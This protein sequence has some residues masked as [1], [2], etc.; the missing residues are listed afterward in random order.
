MARRTINPLFWTLAQVGSR[1]RSGAPSAVEDPPLDLPRPQTTSIPTRH[2]D[3][4]ALVQRPRKTVDPAEPGPV[5]VHLHGGGFVN[6]NPAQDLHIARHL[7]AHLGVVVVLPD[8]DTAPKVRY[9]AA[10]EETVDIV[11][12]V[13][14]S[15]AAG[16]W[17]GN[18]LALSGVSAGAKLAIAACQQLHASAEPQP[19]AVALVV[20]VTD[21]VRIDRSSAIRRP[22]ISPWVQR[23]VAWAY[24]PDAARRGEALAS[25][26]LDRALSRALPPTLVL[27][28][29][30]DTLAP[31]GAELAQV[32]RAGGV[33]VE[34]HQYSGADHGFIAAKPT[35]TIR[36]ALRRM[37][38]FLRP[39]LTTVK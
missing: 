7:A 3:V 16:G 29:E 23:F 30:H 27:T 31:E 1:I 26:R 24:Y 36:D 19:R 35:E 4:R 38:V 34:H 10:E 8:Y 6:R 20:P 22:A 15:G 33:E 13:T 39:H 12:W 5:V 18:R 9:P 14:R 25:P 37:E 17:D 32:L 2:G 28:A 21:A 11:R